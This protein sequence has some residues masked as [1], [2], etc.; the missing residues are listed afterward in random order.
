MEWK[1]LDI[2][3]IPNDFFVNERYEIEYSAIYGM[4]SDEWRP[5]TNEPS[6]RHGIIKIITEGQIQFRYRLKP[7]KSI[8]ITREFHDKF[9]KY[10]PLE[11]FQ[12]CYKDDDTHDLLVLCGR[13]VEIIE[14]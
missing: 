11:P 3:N 7:L 14:E 1:E 12:Q 2:N 9:V 13:K 8:R 4:N 10:S 6:D 5:N